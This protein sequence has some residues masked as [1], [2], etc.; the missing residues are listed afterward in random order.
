MKLSVVLWATLAFLLSACFDS[1]TD[2]RDGQS[3]DVVEI[4]NLTWMA[5]NLNYATESS[6]CPDGDSR[7]CKRMGRLYTWA[8]AQTVCPEGWRLATKAD[9]ESLIAAAVGEDA[10][11]EIAA[12]SPSQSLAGAALK[13]RDGWFKKGNGT[14]EIGFNALPAGYRGAISKADDGAIV[15]GKFD[16]IGGYAYFWSATEESESSE[17][18]AYYLFL[19]FSSDAA[20]INA[21]AKEDYRSVRCVR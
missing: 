20:S 15:G 10:T 19:S 17:S 4:G 8:E 14:D 7:N 16:G 9:F 3:Y 2:A 18:N 1:F 6:A 11:S 21:F 13:A 5:E 12:Q